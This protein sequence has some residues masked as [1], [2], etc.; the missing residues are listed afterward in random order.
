LDY[1]YN[2]TIANISGQGVLQGSSSAAPL[3]LA[4]SDVSIKTY[5]KLAKGAAFRHP[6]INTLN[7][8]KMTQY[9]DNTSQFLNPLGAAIKQNINTEQLSQEL[10]SH[11]TQNATIWSDCI[12]MSG[13]DL[14]SGKCFYYAFI[15]EINYKK[16]QFPTE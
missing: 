11:A 2:N 15:P 4:T 1:P 6:I 10:I 8:T 16:T 12:R 13:G 9:D 7:E 14:N 5:N 3:Y